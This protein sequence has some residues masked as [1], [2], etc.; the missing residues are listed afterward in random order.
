MPPALTRKS[1]LKVELNLKTPVPSL[2]GVAIKAVAV[3][4]LPLMNII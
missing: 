4:A 2:L 1:K 3:P